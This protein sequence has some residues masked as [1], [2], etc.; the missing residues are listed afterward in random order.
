MVS[1]PVVLVGGGCALLLSLFCGFG[2]LMDHVRAR[3]LHQPVGVAGRFTS[4]R[5]MTAAIAQCRCKPDA[6]IEYDDRRVLRRRFDNCI[7]WTTRG[8]PAWCVKVVL[9]LEDSLIT[10]FP[11]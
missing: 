5:V 3:H 7:G 2:R 10:A 1:C 9:A 8:R 6:V 11:Y 4:D